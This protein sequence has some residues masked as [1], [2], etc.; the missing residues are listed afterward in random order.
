VTESFGNR[1]GAGLPAAQR[2][3]E[4]DVKDQE[5]IDLIQKIFADQS[6]AVLATHSGGM[7]YANLMAFA[8]TG[9]LRAL[10][11]VTTR[12]TRKFA[13]ITA[14]ARAAMLID[15]RSNRESDFHAAAAVTATGRVVEFDPAASD[16]FC[17]I[18]LPKHPYLED[19]VRS[20]SSAL[21]RL[22]VDTYH[23]VLQFQNVFEIQMRS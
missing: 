3:C 12:A 22:E 16:E 10:L 6:L 7:P 11:F 13:N 21:L 9:D 20:P 15:N 8:A 2:R 4:V 5:L 18:F 23:L 19:F 1:D 17:G 14:D